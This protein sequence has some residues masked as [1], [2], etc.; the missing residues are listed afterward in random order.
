MFFTHDRIDRFMHEC[1]GSMGGQFISLTEMQAT[2][3]NDRQYKMDIKRILEDGCG[4]NIGVA[5]RNHLVQSIV[6][7]GGEV[8]EYDMVVI[9]DKSVLLGFMIVQKGECRTF[10]ENYCVNLICTKGS[11]GTYLM[12]LYIFILIQDGT[13]VGLLEL[14]NS[15]Y[16][17]GGLC[18]YSKYGFV[19]DPD[20]SS[21][22][23]FPYSPPNLPMKV[24]ISQYGA[25][26][27]EQTDTLFRILL[28][29]DGKFGKPS[30]CDV[31]GAR[32]TLL[33]MALNIKLGK[34]A[35]DNQ[36]KEADD[37]YLYHY[38]YG[39]YVAPFISP[40]FTTVD[41]HRLK[42][43][44][45][46]GTLGCTLEEFIMSNTACV[47]DNVVLEELLSQLV[48]KPPE[49]I[50]EV[51]VTRSRATGGT[52]KRRRIRKRRKTMRRRQRR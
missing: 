9:R 16:N 32:Q 38:R 39:E 29:R 13:K 10:A 23:C 27:E 52:K 7:G 3:K 31:R 14:A 17:T 35:K 22:T 2:R 47:A 44:L 41:Y 28:H 45:E 6:S 30:I 12:A 24:D 8:G 4:A 5:Y 34:T 36:F 37:P 49:V 25:T 48:V 33:G 21:A 1:G 26:K 11:V 51:R 18:L 43:V 46:D 50:P 40:D 19:F 20:L 42:M 15:Y